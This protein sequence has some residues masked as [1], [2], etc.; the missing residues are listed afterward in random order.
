MIAFRTASRCCSASRLASALRAVS[1][2]ASGLLAAAALRAAS[3]RRRQVSSVSATFPPC[4]SGP[5]R[6][7]RSSGFD[8]HHLH[9]S[10]GDRRDEY[11]H[12]AI[13]VDLGA[14]QGSA[15][16][17]RALLAALGLDAGV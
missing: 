14:R 16:R 17:L 15:S 10:D 11:Q 12:S 4:R 9:A 3:L 13:V 5:L 2:R 1:R 7:D 6:L 8:K